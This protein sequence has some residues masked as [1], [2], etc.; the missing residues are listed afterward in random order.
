VTQ[1]IDTEGAA[2]ALDERLAALNA[3]L[4]A[5]REL[6]VAA[7]VKAATGGPGVQKEADRLDGEVQRLERA[8]AVTRDALA[9]VGEASV[10]IADE[11][12][13]AEAARARKKLIAIARKCRKLA[14]AEDLA[15]DGVVAA[16]RALREGLSELFLAA[17]GPTR[18]GE[19]G[20]LSATINNLPLIAVERLAHGD[21]VASRSPLLDRSVPAQS[22][23]DHLDRVLDL[24]APG[25]GRPAKETA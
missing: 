2:A 13:Q 8:V 20:D 19:L 16:R 5:A 9:A 21:V 1:S 17:D 18:S 11:A 7:Q 6:A 12:A 15:L 24:I 14:E 25:P 4:S 3:E 23:A 22:V 10:A